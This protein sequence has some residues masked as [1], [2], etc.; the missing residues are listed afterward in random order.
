MANTRV[1]QALSGEAAMPS[2]KTSR[3]EEALPREALEPWIN[4]AAAAKAQ[5]PYDQGLVTLAPHEAGVRPRNRG[6]AGLHWMRVH[7][8]GA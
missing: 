8:L 6:G 5:H 1:A 4:K 3:V 2:H 7:E